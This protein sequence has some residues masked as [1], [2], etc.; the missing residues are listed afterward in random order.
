M[1]KLIAL[2]IPFFVA[3]APQSAMTISNGQ[4]TV[5]TCRHDAGAVCS[6]KLRGVE[7]IDDY[8]H[9]RQ[10]QSA[11]SFAGYGE[12]YNPTEAGSEQDGLNPSKSTSRL[13]ASWKTPNTLATYTQ[14][15]FWKPV[16]WQFISQ[17][18]LN[19]RV[20]VMPDNVIEYSAQFNVPYNEQHESATFE[21]LT[22]YMPDHFSSFWTYNPVTQSI[23]ALSDG[24]SEQNLPVIMSTPDGQHAMGVWSPELPQSAWPNYGYGRFRFPHER[25]VKWNAVY[26]FTNPSGSYHFRIYVF[27]GTMGEVV[28]NMRRKTNGL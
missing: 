16:G 12:A 14:M 20:Y 4:L 24:N 10:M 23:G 5:K 19:K 25:V 28:E 22:G 3:A 6:V 27:A 9:G 26:R 7:Y 17:H 2:L 15:A 13:I 8:D 1:I 21:V 18:T 11:S